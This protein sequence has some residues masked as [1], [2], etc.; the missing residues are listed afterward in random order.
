MHHELPYRYFDDEHHVFENTASVG[1]G[2]KMS[3]LVGANDE[4]IQTLNSLM[5]NLKEGND[6]DY[7]FVL[8]GNNQVEHLIDANCETLSRRGG[9]MEKFAKNE[10]IYA[11]HAS[12][13]GFKIRS[14]I[15]YYDLKNYELLFFTSTTKT[16]DELVALKN[17][18]ESELAQIGLNPQPMNAQDFICYVHDHVN[19]N[20]IQ[21]KPTE[22]DYNPLDCIHEQVM[23][24][25]TAFDVDD[26]SVTTSCTALLSKKQVRTSIVSLGLKKLPSEMRLYQLPEMLASVLNPEKS[27]VC[28]HR[29]SVNFRI[30]STG[31]ESLNNTKKIKGLDK[32]VHS[33]MR[34][35]VPQAEDELIERRDLQRGLLEQEFKVGA[36][37]LTV[38]LYT[39]E[40][41]Q[42]ES[43]TKAISTFEKA[44]L[45]MVNTKK[46]QIN[47]FLAV[48]PFQMSEGFFDDCK[49]FGRF[50]SIKTSNLVNFL[51]V[52]AELKN[53]SGG[54]LLPTMRHQ[55]SF[56]DPFNCGCDN[57]N[58]A[59]TG[60]SGSGKSFFMQSLAKGVMVS[61]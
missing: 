37:M 36:M 53:F 7:Q 55:L 12:K 17:I 24:P 57:Y 41:K 47:S 15:H 51:P 61:F 58:I 23:S 1:F 27:L 20:L 46:M 11:K 8:V 4:V 9:I 44:K 14:K 48:L 35:F 54:M 32:I 19:F 39:N 6:W 38:S 26:E 50:R 49:K 3:V 5:L 2:L 28:P 18:L 13:Y 22:L 29:I 10:A 21:T 59:L 45:D 33:P 40:Q 42:L 34:M 25:D 16:K 60:G 31:R 30:L 43:I 52:V 56:F